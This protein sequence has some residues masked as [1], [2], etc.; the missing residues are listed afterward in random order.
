[1]TRRSRDHHFTHVIAIMLI[2]SV[3]F[4]AC[5]TISTEPVATTEK[6]STEIT[7]Y[8]DSS[9]WSFEAEGAETMPISSDKIT[10]DDTD[11][12]AH[13]HILPVLHL[14]VIALV[15]LLDGR[16]TFE[17]LRQIAGVVVLCCHSFYSLNIEN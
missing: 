6:K 9:S 1:M 2:S 8:P 12:D 16:K 15:A 5:Q 14:I 17:V 10:P 13:E 3:L 7:L 11:D 4:C